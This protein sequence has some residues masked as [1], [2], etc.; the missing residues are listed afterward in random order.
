MC[1]SARPGERLAAI[2][3][4]RDGQFGFGPGGSL[5]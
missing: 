4:V 2:G 3:L 5:D 1:K